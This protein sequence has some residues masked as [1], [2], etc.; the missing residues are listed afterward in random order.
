M[1]KTTLYGAATASLLAMAAM[2]TPGFAARATPIAPQVEKNVDT[3][4]HNR[5]HHRHHHYDSYHYG[6]GYYSSGPFFF[7]PW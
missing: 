6:P 7:R 5:R 4:Q 3:V 1:L 2:T